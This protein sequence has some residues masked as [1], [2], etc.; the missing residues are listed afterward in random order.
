MT[1]LHCAMIDLNRASVARQYKL[2]VL[3]WIN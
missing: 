2:L 3:I 1:S